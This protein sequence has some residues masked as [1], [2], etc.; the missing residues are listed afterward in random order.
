MPVP[1]K[2]YKRVFI[3]RPTGETNPPERSVAKLNLVVSDSSIL[4]V[5]FRIK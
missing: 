2:V 4:F 3:Y 1:L 5:M